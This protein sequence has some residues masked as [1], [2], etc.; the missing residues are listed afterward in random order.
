MTYYEDHREELKAKALERQLQQL[1]DWADKELGM[2]LELDK[3]YVW[4]GLSS[5]KKNYLGL[6]PDGKLVVKGL[7]GKKRHT[8]EFIKFVYR[9]VLE[10]LKKMEKPEQLELVKSQIVEFVKGELATLRG[11][12]VPVA[13]LAFTMGLQKDPD[14]YDGNPIHVKVA[15]SVPGSKAGDVIRFVKVLGPAGARHVSVSRPEEINVAAYEE[16]LKNTLIQV[17]DCIG[18]DWEDV[19]GDVSQQ[20]LFGD[21]PISKPKALRL[22]RK[23]KNVVS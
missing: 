3:T 23:K 10:I 20:T 5:R 19:G 7:S 18:L 21:M 8:P 13:V 11:R 6:S 17:F 1:M 12:R 15:R 16:F 2:K 9:G 4:L 22:Q 14:D